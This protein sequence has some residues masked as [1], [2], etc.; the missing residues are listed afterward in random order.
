MSGESDVTTQYINDG[1]NVIAEITGEKTQTYIRG[2]RLIAM[3]DEDGA[4]KPKG[5]VKYS[6]DIKPC[7]RNE[8]HRWSNNLGADGI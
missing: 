2:K 7:K 4:W 3:Q 5:L 6:R 1:G 8:G